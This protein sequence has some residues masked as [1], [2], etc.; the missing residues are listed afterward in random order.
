MDRKVNQKQ[1]ISTIGASGLIMF[2]N[3]KT[4]K[5]LSEKDGEDQEKLVSLVRKLTP[6]RVYAHRKKEGIY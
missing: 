6:Q 1:N 5:W 3:N 4:G 2:M